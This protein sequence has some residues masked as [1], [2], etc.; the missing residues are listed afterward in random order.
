M[1]APN[2]TL[3]IQAFNF[4]I[5][6]TILRAYI[7]APALQILNQQESEKKKLEKAISATMLKKESLLMHVQ[8][9]WVS[10]KKALCELMPSLGMKSLVINSTMHQKELLQ[11]Q[12]IDLSDEKRQK[13][14]RMIRNSV[15]EVK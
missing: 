4:F 12:Q 7:F 13:L 9:R 6:Y 15:V 2:I 8:E 10:I 11:N 3:L 5:A 1:N 14:K